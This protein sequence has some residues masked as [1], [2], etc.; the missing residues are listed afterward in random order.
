MDFMD[1][2][3]IDIHFYFLLRALFSLNSNFII[4]IIYFLCCERK[5]GV[6]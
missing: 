4:L 1:M 2:D 5:N 3:F 6:Y